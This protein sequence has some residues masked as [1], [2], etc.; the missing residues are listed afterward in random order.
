MRFLEDRRRKFERRNVVR[1][2]RALAA[3][4]KAEALDGEARVEGGFD[5]VDRFAAGRAE[6]R[7][8]LDHRAGVRHANAEH[9]AGVRR[10]LLE[11]E[12]LGVVVIRDERLVL[13]QF[14]QRGDILNRIRVDD[15][16]PD[17][18]LPL[19]GRQVLD[20]LVDQA[21][22]GHR[23]HVKARA[24]FIERLDDFRI[25]V[26]LHRVVRLH[27][28]QVFLERGVVLA[29]F[30]MVDDEERC[31]MVFGQFLERGLRDH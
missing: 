22:L 23:G 9:Q 20:V 4:V 14:D 8:Q 6:L 29:Q 11:L 3:D 2:I 15:F 5:Q 1:E 26:R 18:I 16:V 25:G 12:N 13:V 30:V 31:A 17:E 7:R 19:F 24:G 10:V 27:A 21:K 28:R